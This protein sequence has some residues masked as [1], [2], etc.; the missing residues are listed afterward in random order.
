MMMAPFFRFDGPVDFLLVNEPVR[1]MSSNFIN[2][3]F[4]EFCLE[5]PRLCLSVSLKSA[6]DERMKEN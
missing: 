1:A 3:G 5:V 2:I 6:A 4:W